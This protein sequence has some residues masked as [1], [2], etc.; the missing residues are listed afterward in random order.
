MRHLLLVAVCA[1]ALI[2]GFQQFSS[3]QAKQEKSS[4]EQSQLKPKVDI[5][6][7]DATRLEVNDYP[8]AV[9]TSGRA[10]NSP[11]DVVGQYKMPDGK[12]HGFLLRSGRYQSIDVPGADFTMV[13]GLNDRGDMV[14]AFRHPGGRNSAYILRDGKVTALQVPNARQSSA[15]QINS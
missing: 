9:E 4:P 12:T 6:V 15:F 7:D 5:G 10:I 11:G 14:G 1:S 2:F 13:R 3:T 8:G